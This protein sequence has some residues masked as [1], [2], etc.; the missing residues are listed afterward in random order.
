[1][2][3]KINFKLNSIV[4]VFLC[5]F[6]LFESCTKDKTGL[7]LKNKDFKSGLDNYLNYIDTSNNKKE[8]LVLITAFKEIDSVIFNLS[9]STTFSDLLTTCEDLSDS[10]ISLIDRIK[11]QRL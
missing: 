7:L 5:I 4:I 6:F 2:E 1:M 11:I 3:F 9:L 10:S 8:A